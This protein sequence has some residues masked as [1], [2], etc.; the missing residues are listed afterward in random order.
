MVRTIAVI[1]ALLLAS[2]QVPAPPPLVEKITVNVVNV[3][4][5]VMDKRGHPVRGLPGGDCENIEDDQPQE[6]SNVSVIDD[7]AP[8]VEARRDAAAP[9]AAPPTE[10]RFR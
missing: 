10:E 7:A 9:E 4:V 3:D 5:T 2:A 6:G 1:A 8:R